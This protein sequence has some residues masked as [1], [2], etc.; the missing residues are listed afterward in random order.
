MSIHRILILIFI[1]FYFDAHSQTSNNNS[2]IFKFEKNIDEPFTKSETDKI[3]RAYG[4]EKFQAIISEK[5]LE[6]FYKNILRN[7]VKIRLKKYYPNENLPKLSSIGP[8]LDEKNL[9][10]D[11]FNPLKYNFP[12]YSK[13]SHYYRVNQTDF[14]VVINPQELE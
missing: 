10:S 1:L 4:A 7:R 3:I 2:W 5:A 11:K 6:K 12:F 9:S 13:K 14:L 8:M